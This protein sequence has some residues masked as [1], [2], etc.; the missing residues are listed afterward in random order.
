MNKKFSIIPLFIV[1]ILVGMLIMYF[2][3]TYK[4]EKIEPNTSTAQTEENHTPLL[5]NDVSESELGFTSNE[6]SAHNIDELTEENRVIDYVKKHHE[7]PSFYI[8][9]SE[10]RKR[11][12]VASEGNL[13]DV[14]PGRAIGGD[15]FS[16]REKNL[17]THQQYYEADVN[18]NCGRR[19]KDRIVF[20]KN[21]D[22]YL[23]KNHYKSFE[24]Q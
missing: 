2:F 20:T 1:G 9:K 21:G 14:L 24:K 10:A 18:Y 7:L 17:P 11:G 12:W 13:C 16:N 4:I 6:N 23:T 8:T 22:V 15:K 5:S 19:G 3:K